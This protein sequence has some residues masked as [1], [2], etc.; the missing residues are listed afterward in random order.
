MVTTLAKTRVAVDNSRC[1]SGAGFA[2][3]DNADALTLASLAVGAVTVGGAV[4][5]G[6]TVLPAQ[7]ATGAVATAALAVA[8]H[9]KTK[10]GHYLPFLHGK[11]EEKTVTA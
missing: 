8:G 1:D 7:V 11:D 10:T 5:V 3:L 4:A 9:S 2:A 6:V